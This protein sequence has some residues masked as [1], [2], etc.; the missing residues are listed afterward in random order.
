MKRLL[1]LLIMAISFISACTTVEPGHRGVKVYWGGKP[2][3]DYVLPEGMEVGI[4]WL[5]NSC[6]E[7]DV[8]EKTLVEKFVFNDSRN[9]ETSVEIALD[10]NLNPQQVNLLHTRITD[11]DTKILKTLK[12][13]GKEVVPQYTA[14]ELNLKKRKEAE[15]AL[16]EIISKELPEFYVQFARVQITDVDIPQGLA[17]VAEETAIQEGRNS[18]AAK[19]ELEQTNLAKARIAEAKGKYDAALYDAK[20]KDVLSSPKM[21]ELKKLEIEMEWARKGV[22]KYGNNNVFGAGTAVLKGID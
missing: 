10:Y 11:V 8:R 18:L 9:M 19:K 4:S 22:S 6:V 20:T 3:M 16:R 12:S 13:A 5:W 7:Y 1:V 2:E 21:L 15:A 14:S 17:K